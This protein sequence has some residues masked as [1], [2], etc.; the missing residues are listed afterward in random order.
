M[1]EGD[2]PIDHYTNTTE[3]YDI[4]ADM[5]IREAPLPEA[6]AWL[7]AATVGDLIFAMGGACEVP[8][9]TGI[10]WIGDMH[11]FVM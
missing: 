11:E 7:D 4:D 5:W 9:P 2:D 1:N 8:G 10:K 6:K 3:V